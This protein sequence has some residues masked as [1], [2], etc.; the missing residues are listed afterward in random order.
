MK[1]TSSAL[2]LGKPAPYSI[3]DYNIVP[4]YRYRPVVLSDTDPAFISVGQY[5]K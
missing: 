4:R 1:I 2:A 3:P 5:W